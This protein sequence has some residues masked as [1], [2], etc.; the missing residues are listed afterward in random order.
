MPAAGFRETLRPIL[1]RSPRFAACAFALVLSTL[2]ACGDDDAVVPDGAVGCA[3]HSDCDDGL[4][5]NG[6]EQCLPGDPAA[7]PMGCV[8][9]T[10]SCMPTQVCDEGARTCETVCAVE[11]DADGDGHEALACGGDDC[12]DADA[13]RNP[14]AAEVCDAE[15]RDEDCRPDTFGDRD[16]DGDGLVSALCCNGADCG[17]DCN[18]NDRAASPGSPEVC[19]GADNDCDGA[20]DEGLTLELFRD[21]D[22]D[23]VGAAGSS[24][25]ACPGAPGYASVAGDCDDTVASIRPTAPEI[26]DGEDNDCDGVVDENAVAIPW[27][28]DRDGDGWG[29]VSA[30]DPSIESCVPPEGRAIRPGDCDDDD[31]AVSPEAPERCNGLDDDCNGRA[32]YRI[33]VGDGE[34]DD[35]DGLPDEAC[36]AP[37]ADCDDR[38]PNTRG[39]DS[40]EICDGADNDCD[41]TVDEDAAATDWYADDDGDGFGDPADGLASC[42]PIPGRVTNDDDCDDTNRSTNPKAADACSG[43][44]AID[45]DCDGTV[46]E[47][48]AGGV[49]VG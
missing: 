44:P 12:D 36:G 18:D 9:G 25:I 49:D 37:T 23:G 13:E 15:G 17:L 19:D 41:G 27:Y 20:I 45:D 4:F 5:C 47:A 22:H 46:D 35:R 16:L 48:V 38:D 6:V 29:V 10:T 26:C 42:A 34:D 14:S 11:A 2:A 40:P 3:A 1:L 33:A 28:V 8:S 39:A 32:D 24:T 7:D 31:A 30:A 43:Q 21:A